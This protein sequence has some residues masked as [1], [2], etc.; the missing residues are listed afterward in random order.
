[1]EKHEAFFNRVDENR[2]F[3]KK[4]KKLDFFDLNLIFSI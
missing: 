2:D 3:S 1:M 4:L